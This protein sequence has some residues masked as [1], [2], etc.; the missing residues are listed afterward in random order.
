M[1]DVHK[2]TYEIFKAE[3][4]DSGILDIELLKIYEKMIVRADELLQIFKD[5]NGKRTF[6]LPNYSSSQQRT[7]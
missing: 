4:V 6:H 3:F 2:K 5:E 1:P 7:G